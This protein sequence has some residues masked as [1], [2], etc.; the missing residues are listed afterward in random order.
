MRNSM[1][2]AQRVVEPTSSE[3]AVG[4]RCAGPGGRRYTTGRTTLRSWTHRHS[5]PPARQPNP[6]RPQTIYRHLHRGSSIRHRRHLLC[7]S[8][9]LW[10]RSLQ[11]LWLPAT[12][13]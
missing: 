2:K 4:D 3:M 5:I 12:T 10:Q 9:Q 13:R 1:K 8:F 6:Q 7:R 11:P